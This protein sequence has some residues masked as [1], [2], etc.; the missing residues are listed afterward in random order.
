VLG[1]RAEGVNSTAQRRLRPALAPVIVLDRLD[2]PAAN[3]RVRMSST[4]DASVRTATS[5]P[6]ERSSSRIGVS[7]NRCPR[8]GEV[9]A[10]TRLIGTSHH[11]LEKLV[12]RHLRL[13]ATQAAITAQQLP[14]IDLADGDELGEPA[15]TVGA[16]QPV[17]HGRETPSQQPA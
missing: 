11:R 3:P 13:A 16:T 10:R 17:E 5:W 6:R 12:Q 14:D 9:Y 7:G 15:V 4:W 1:T 8:A 2:G